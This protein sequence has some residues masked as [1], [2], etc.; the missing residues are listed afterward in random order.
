MLYNGA[1]TSDKATH[2]D[3]KHEAMAVVARDH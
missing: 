2:D 1:A 3:G